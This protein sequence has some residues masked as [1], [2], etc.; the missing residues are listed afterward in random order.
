VKHREQYLAENH[1]SRTKPWQAEGISRRTWYRHRKA[2][3]T[4]P[5]ASFLNICLVQRHG[6]RARI[7]SLS[8]SRGYDVILDES[9]AVTDVAIIP[10]ER[11]YLPE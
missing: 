3:G 7:G 10:N 11:T 9:G 1:L 4:S 6:T 8:S 2:G 5:S